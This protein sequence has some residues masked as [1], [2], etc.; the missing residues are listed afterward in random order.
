MNT[1]INEIYAL[2]SILL[3]VITLLFGLSLW[4]ASK[5][6][7]T[8]FNTLNNKINTLENITF[9]RLML[10]EEQNKKINEMDETII[11][12]IEQNKLFD[13]IHYNIVYDIN[14][15]EK[16]I[17][18]ILDDTST[19]I[20]KLK[21]KI[22]SSNKQIK[23]THANYILEEQLKIDELKTQI[24]ELSTN[25]SLTNDKITNVE[26]TM[27]TNEELDD[28]FNTLTRYLAELEITKESITAK[29]LLKN[30]NIL[31]PVNCWVYLIRYNKHFYKK[32]LRNTQ[33]NA[34]V[35]NVEY[36]HHSGANDY[37]SFH[38]YNRSMLSIAVGRNSI[39][40][41]DLNSKVGSIK[42]NYHINIGVMEGKVIKFG[43]VLDRVI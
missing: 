19:K 28:S 23:N 9:E 12:L 18:T 35:Y 32:E 16:T 7:N 17:T 14:N 34:P 6:A 25:L 3:I 39:R 8:I 29:L 26:N 22:V 5:A 41:E 43:T 30:D 36:L 24:N 42:D 4:L 20:K 1:T 40:L 38:I 37:E 10:I 2:I 15:I 27:V 33:L 21:T 13:K 11:S 31:K